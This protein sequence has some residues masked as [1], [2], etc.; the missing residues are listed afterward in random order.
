MIEKRGS[1]RT[2]VLLGV[3]LLVVGLLIRLALYF[4]P[5]LFQVDADAVI[6][7]LC[8]FRVAEGHFPVFLPGGVRVGAASCY[9]AAAYFHA[10]GPVRAALA[11]T[12]LTWS[13]FYLAF[14]LLLLRTTLGPKLA[15]V[16]FLFAVVPA[17]QFMTVAYAPWGYG[18]IVASCAASLWL[19]SEWRRG[20]AV[21]QRLCFGLSV[22]LGVWFSLQTLMV[23]LPAIVWLAAERRNRFLKES[24]VAVA[25]AIAGAAPFLLGN[26]AH[27][28]PSLT[29]NWYSQPVSSVSQASADLLW[30]LTYLLPQLLSRFPELPESPI[31]MG[32][33]ALVAIGFVLAARRGSGSLGTPIGLA[34]VGQL[35]ALVLAACVLIFGFSHAGTLRGWTVRYIA[36]LYVVVPIFCGAGIAGLWRW[37][38]PLATATAAALLV[39]NLCFY[40][41]P[42]SHLRAILANRLLD[43][44]H[45]R[46]VLA[47]HRVRAVY[48]NYDW[49]YNLNFDSREL[50]AGVPAEAAYDY[51]AY[52][53]RLGTSPV[54][55][56][57]LGR[58]DEV[59]AWQ[60]AAGAHGTLFQNDELWVFIADRP[61][62]NAALLFASLGRTPAAPTR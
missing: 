6:A 24:L 16:G 27:G 9:L 45:L 56:A 7:G 4:P 57:L 12:S 59:S 23:A 14:T 34:G 52:G 36:P 51:Y 29:Q 31:L 30:L 60:R 42:G 53:D 49:V 40:S 17:E 55:W 47:Q 35:L 32:A 50:L 22:G 39:T 3:A 48:G 13:A 18:E 44:N 19:A 15:L 54:R 62:P 21:W 25:G 5:A 11:L 61:A 58:R 33:F 28:F 2:W 8:A 38:R 37:S 46:E 43:E 20:G 10:L 41:L 1:G 26:A